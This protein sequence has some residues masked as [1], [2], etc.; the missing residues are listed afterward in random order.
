MR[1]LRKKSTDL[2]GTNKRKCGGG[3]EERDPIGLIREALDHCELD[4]VIGK[5]TSAKL[6]RKKAVE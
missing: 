1:P 3:I 2:H 6:S 4:L 5:K